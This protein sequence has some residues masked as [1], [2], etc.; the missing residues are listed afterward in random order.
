MMVSFRNRLGRSLRRA[1]RDYRM[2]A[3]N[4]AAVSLTQTC[5]FGAVLFWRIEKRVAG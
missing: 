5:N 3:G 1:L 2:L 4:A